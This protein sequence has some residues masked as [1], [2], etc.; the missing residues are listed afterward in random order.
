MRAAAVFGL[1][2]LA[3]ALSGA[4]EIFTRSGGHLTGEVVSRDAE[5]IVVDIG[6][7]RVELPLSYVE[8]VETSEAPIT[9]Y[10]R[11]AQALADDDA[12]GWLAL[13]RWAREQD[14]GA[15]AHEALIR[16][17]EIEPDNGPARLALG[18]VKYN[19][20]WMTQQESYQAQGLVPFEG[21]WVR[22]E[23]REL[24]LAERKAVAEQMHREADTQARVRETE[25]LLR[26]AE[27]RARTAEAQVRVAEAEAHAAEVQS[28]AF[29]LPFA[30]PFF[31]G[32]T[33]SWGLAPVSPIIT[34]FSA[35]VPLLQD[36]A[37]SAMRGRRGGR[38]RVVDG[39]NGVEPHRRGTGQRQHVRRREGPQPPPPPLSA[40]GQDR[41]C[42]DPSTGLRRPSCG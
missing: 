6:I 39:S 26:E 2:C 29:P 31:N 35:P 13:S 21:R 38:D 8:R 41:S 12:A 14:L 1:L 3:P 9:V 17:V 23:E 28:E 34:V 18:H 11:R 32:F 15:Q 16:V 10:R 27:A 19:D 4:D 24:A 37:P 36:S 30:H 20:Q 5:R 25:A 22:P 7:G 33:S 40:G 42:F